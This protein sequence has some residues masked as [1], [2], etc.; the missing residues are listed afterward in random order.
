MLVCVSARAR[1]HVGTIIIPSSQMGKS[2]LSQSKALHPSLPDC[3]ASVLCAM[4]RCL[5]KEQIANGGISDAVTVLWEEVLDRW[6]PIG[7]LPRASRAEGCQGRRSTSP[8]ILLMCGMQTGP[9]WTP[10]HLQPAL[11]PRLGDLHELSFPAALRRSQLG[12]RL[13][14]PLLLGSAKR[15]GA[16]EG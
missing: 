3:K 6:F 2:T 10:H 8:S 9:L 4:P 11:W 14:L 5:P 15:G 16:A 7:P 1:E 12:Q 13:S